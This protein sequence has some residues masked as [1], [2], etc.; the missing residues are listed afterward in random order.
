M[1]RIVGA[2]IALIVRLLMIINAAFMLA[3]PRAWFRLPAGL[4]AQGSL[5]EGRYSSGL[6]SHPSSTDRS[7]NS[8]SY[9]VGFL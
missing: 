1:I 8:C 7:S 9:N 4:K 3:S 5:T 2:F 6:A